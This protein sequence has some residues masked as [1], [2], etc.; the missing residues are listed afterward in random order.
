MNHK[1]M[2]EQR[3]TSFCYKDEKM[4]RIQKLLDTR[5]LEAF[6]FSFIRLVFVKNSSTF[7]SVSQNESIHFHFIASW[8]ILRTHLRNVKRKKCEHLK[9]WL[10]LWDET[11]VLLLMHLS[12]VSSN[13]IIESIDGCIPQGK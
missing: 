7:H 10:D 11:D 12:L 4:T 9:G 2:K 5:I 3:R 6:S 13:L 8:C 1:I